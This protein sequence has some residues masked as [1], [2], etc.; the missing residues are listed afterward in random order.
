MTASTNVDFVTLP[1]VT[2]IQSK[3]RGDVVHR[4]AGVDKWLQ[5]GFCNPLELLGERAH[6][7]VVDDD[8]TRG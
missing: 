7:H 4:Q 5:G 3:V 2:H 8:F 1:V 6:I